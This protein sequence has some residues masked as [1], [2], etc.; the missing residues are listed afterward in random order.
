M[1]HSCF[2]VNNEVQTLF[3]RI[4]IPNKNTHM[5]RNNVN[6]MSKKFMVF[7]FFMFQQKNLEKWEKN[8]PSQACLCR[9]QKSHPRGQNLT[10]DS[11][12]LVPG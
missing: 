12:S 10:R 6:L 7:G 8:N 3:Q 5:L 2:P 9:I 4:L 1:L 11:A